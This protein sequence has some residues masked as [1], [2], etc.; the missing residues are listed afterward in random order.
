M[1]SRYGQNLPVKLDRNL[2]KRSVNGVQILRAILYCGELFPSIQE[3]TGW[4]DDDKIG[5]FIG[6]VSSGD[7]RK[8]D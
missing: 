1:M 2:G 4:D 7:K 8:A 3:V 6:E 5:N